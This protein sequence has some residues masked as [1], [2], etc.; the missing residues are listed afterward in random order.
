MKANFSLYR[1]FL[2]GFVVVAA[3]PLLFGSLYFYKVLQR[4]LRAEVERINLV[5]AQAAGNQ[6][7]GHIQEIDR[8][9]SF[10]A[11]QY[12]FKKKGSEIISWTY[13]QH[14]EVRKLVVVDLENRVVEAVSRYGYMSPGMPSPLL[15]FESAYPQQK[16][17]LFSQW[18][19]E[20]QML[21]VFPYGGP[22]KLDNMLSYRSLTIQGDDR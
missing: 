1:K 2:S 20:P 8:S 7:G 6:V 4:H 10:A 9:L 13:R 19:L 21:M 22:Q 15:A 14:P 11:S 16:K 17:I 5:Q 3:L 18:Q 12:L